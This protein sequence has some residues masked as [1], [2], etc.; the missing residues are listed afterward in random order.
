MIDLAAILG[1]SAVGSVIGIVG[2][3]INRREDAKEAE[4]QRQYDLAKMRLSADIEV[5]ASDAK[6]YYE[7]Q[8]TEG[9]VASAIK[10]AVRPVITGILMYQTYRIMISLEELTGGLVNLPEGEAFELYKL[11][12]LNIVGLTSTAINW[13]FASR[14]SGLQKQLLLRAR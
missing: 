11:I 14:P 6:A 12:A 5:K 3:W 8:K 4:K 13:W 1:S 9:K 2:G 10:S 7:S